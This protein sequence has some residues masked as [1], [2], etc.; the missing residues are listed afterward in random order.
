MELVKQDPKQIEGAVNPEIVEDMRL[1]TPAEL[2][3]I[4]SAM[5]CIDSLHGTFAPDIVNA[6]TA[7]VLVVAFTRSEMP[8]EAFLKLMSENWDRYQES[9]AVSQEVVLETMR[10][11]REMDL[12]VYSQKSTT[13]HEQPTVTGRLTGGKNL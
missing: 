7:A 12:S 11:F 1:G 5:N 13:F 9:L 10:K 8:K 2:L 4:R 3:E 6:A